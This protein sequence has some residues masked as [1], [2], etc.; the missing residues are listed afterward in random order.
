VVGDG[1][2]GVRAR[3]LEFMRKKRGMWGD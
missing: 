1:M 3:R 2:G